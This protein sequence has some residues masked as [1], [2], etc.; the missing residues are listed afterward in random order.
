MKPYLL[1]QF[2]PCFWIAQMGAGASAAPPG[3]Y[4]DPGKEDIVACQFVQQCRSLRRKYLKCADAS[5]ATKIEEWEMG[6]DGIARLYADAAAKE[7]GTSLLGEQIPSHSDFVQ[8][9]FAVVN[10]MNSGAFRSFAHERIHFSQTAFELHQQF[11]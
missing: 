7:A 10:M 5:A 3:V 8:D 9:Y 11:Q 2:P 6:G 4:D 1:L